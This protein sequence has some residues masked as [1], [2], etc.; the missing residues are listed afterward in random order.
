LVL[1]VQVYLGFRVFLS[2]QEDRVVHNQAGLV[3]LLVLENQE[4]LVDLQNKKYVNIKYNK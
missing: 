2:L 3:L 4:G 1:D